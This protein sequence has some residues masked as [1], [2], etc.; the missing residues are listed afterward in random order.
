[1][2]AGFF[3]RSGDAVNR[4]YDEAGNLIET[5]QHTGSFKDFEDSQF[6]L[7]HEADAYG[8]ALAMGPSQ[9]AG[10]I[11]KTSVD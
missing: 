3:S 11:P 9:E 6:C 1:M 2:V 10:D 7:P 8:A 4:A 5:L